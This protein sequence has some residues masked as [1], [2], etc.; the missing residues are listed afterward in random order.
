MKLSESG[1][2]GARQAGLTSSLSLMNSSKDHEKVIKFAK[3]PTYQL[4]LMYLLQDD[5]CFL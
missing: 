5:H 3:T 1:F 4:P 2:G